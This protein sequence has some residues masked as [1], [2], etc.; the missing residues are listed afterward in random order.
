MQRRF[1]VIGLVVILAAG[2]AGGYSFRVTAAP[3]PKGQ[4]KM[5]MK[6]HGGMAMQTPV[7]R[8]LDQ[9]LEAAK[10]R[11]A[12][13]GKYKCCI[14][15]SCS[16]CMLHMGNCTCYKGVVSGKGH[17]RECRGGWEAGQGHVPGKTL[18]DVRK[19]KVESM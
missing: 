10:T 14:K 1:S 3:A 11:A 13:R 19:M 2:L 8:R 6:E 16:W 15:P 9:Q 4:A 7:S 17:C 18:A 5:A 12:R